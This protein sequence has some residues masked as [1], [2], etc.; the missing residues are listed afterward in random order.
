MYTATYRS[1]T[2]MAFV[3]LPTTKPSLRTSH[4]QRTAVTP[5]RRHVTIAATAAA[6]Q[7]AAAAVSTSMPFPLNDRLLVRVDESASTSAGGLLIAK[8]S[9]E[10]RETPTTGTV[11]AVGPGRYSPDGFHESLDFFKEGDKI[12]WKNDFGSET[13][14][15]TDG[16]E[17]LTLR[18]FSVIAK[19]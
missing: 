3:L 5:L 14:R 12:L 4:L 19:Y 16:T 11:L 6:S 18:A 9:D 1:L 7:P 13:I 10:N 8:G 2:T 15:G 17:Y